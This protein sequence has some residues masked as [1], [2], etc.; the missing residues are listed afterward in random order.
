MQTFVAKKAMTYFHVY[1]KGLEDREIFRDRADF[2]AGMNILAVVCIS[3]KVR[4]L[5][6]V[7]MSNHVHFL[8]QGDHDAADR[9]IW[10]YKNLVSRYLRKR[11]REVGYLRRIVTTVAE[12]ESDE[13][14]L[15]RLIA[16]ILNNPVKAGINCV[17]QGYEWSSARCYFNLMNDTDNSTSVS[18]YSARK[19]SEI[20]HSRKNLPP[21]WSINASGY[22][23]PR[24][25]VESAAVERLY[26]RS[27]SFEYFLSTSLSVRKGVFENITFSDAVLIS[28]LNELLEKKYAVAHV[29][30][31]ND[32]LKTNLLKDLKSRFSAS[33]KQLAR[34][35]GMNISDIIRLMT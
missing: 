28:A 32:F 14:A 12:V 4:L 29:S 1:T 26:G 8:L 11:Y 23:V 20:L 25:Y 9:F 3:C 35:L 34:V 17:P 19:L 16:Y 13:E 7:L 24:C 31:L 22:V 6:F 5:A 21:Y 27:R 15:K 18:E 2:I 33:S 30:E 10:L